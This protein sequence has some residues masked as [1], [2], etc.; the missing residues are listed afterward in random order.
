MDDTIYGRLRFQ[1]LAKFEASGALG[2]V[3]EA[4]EVLAAA[5]KSPL[6]APPIMDWPRITQCIRR[7]SM[8]ALMAEAPGL[9]ASL[10]FDPAAPNEGD[11]EIHVSGE[12]RHETGEVLSVLPLEEEALYEHKYAMLA[13]FPSRY[14]LITSAADRQGTQQ[15]WLVGIQSWREVRPEEIEQAE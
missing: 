1:N 6:K 8:F 3:E 13:Q 15:V 9:R 4:L 2:P 12:R 14:L 10:R 5:A 11:Y 7:G